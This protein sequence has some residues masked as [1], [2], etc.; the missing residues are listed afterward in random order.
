MVEVIAF[1]RPLLYE[2]DLVVELH[3]DR[4]AAWAHFDPARIEPVLTNLL[5]NAIRYSKPGTAVCVRCRSVPAENHGFIELS[6][7]DTGPGIAFEDQERIFE[8]YVRSAG[9][10]GLGLGLA[11]C[12]R[13]VTAHGGS[14]SVCHEPG[15][16]ARFT[17]SL[18]AA[19]VEAAEHV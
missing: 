8:P 5:S 11:I 19:D 14:L 4:D 16:G 6:V 10:T 1:L 9:S 13:I 17:F 2:Q 18:A 7:I 3:I 12:R 15:W